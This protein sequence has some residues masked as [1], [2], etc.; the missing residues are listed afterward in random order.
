MRKVLFSVLA[1]GLLSTVVLAQP[2]EVP[3]G[4]RDQSES[5]GRQLNDRMLELAQKFA[6]TK[7]V[8]ERQG[9]K[10]ELTKVVE[11]Q[12]DVMVKG[13]EKQITD[14]EV[15]LVEMRKNLKEKVAIKDK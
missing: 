1:V 7:D 12:F 3:G 2:L 10:Q 14:G 13:Q 11:E 9:V 5:L 15:R 8:I 6:D 4:P